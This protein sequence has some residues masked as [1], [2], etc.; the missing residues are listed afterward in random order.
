MLL[1]FSLPTV[2]YAIEILL[3][4]QHA[5]TLVHAW[6]SVRPSEIQIIFHD[7]VLLRSR[8]REGM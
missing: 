4:P 5:L 2:M 7:S 8:G 1:E 6:I 3:F